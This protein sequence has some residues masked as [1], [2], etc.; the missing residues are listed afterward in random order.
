[1]NLHSK[2]IDIS[3]MVSIGGI[4][5]HIMV[6]GNP[7]NPII[8]FIHG[9][10][11]IPYSCIS[12]CFQ[13]NIEQDFLVVNWDQ[14]G[15]GKSY[16]ENIPIDTMNLEQFII[17]L[18]EVV[19]YLLNTY[20]K[21]KLFLS[22][23]S[24]GSVYGLMSVHRFP[25]KFYGYISTGQIVD[26]IENEKVSYNLI[27]N[28]AKKLNNTEAI[29]ELSE[30]GN[31][32]YKDMIHDIGIERKWLSI[33]GY[34]EKNFGVFEYISNNCTREELDIIMKGQE[35]S[36]NHLFADIYENGINFF[37]TIK[38]M[39]V[40]VYFCM[41]RYDYVAPQKLTEKYCKTLECPTKK[42]IWFENSAHFPELDEPDKFYKVLLEILHTTLD[43]K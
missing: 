29:K 35:F 33:L 30:I 6:R 17:D 34:I 41:G 8:L 15:A 18:M 23:Q 21:N 9:G 38:D 7:Q 24:I 43:K 26:T 3:E 40:P 13:E 20:K 2:K 11:G 28:E 1:M 16:N 12:D 5:Q 14:R 25:D 10:P 32:P 39:K 37:E 19:D 4:K 31:P 36:V 27:F 22:A 42:C